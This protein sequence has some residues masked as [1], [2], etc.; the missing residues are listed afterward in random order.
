[1]QLQISMRIHNGIIC[2]KSDKIRKVWVA[3][4]F[5][6]ARTHLA[7]PDLGAHLQFEVVALGNR[8]RTFGKLTFF[9][10]F[11]N[12]FAAILQQVSTFLGCSKAKQ[13][14]LKQERIFLSRKICSKMEK[15]V[16]E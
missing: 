2:S 5:G 3:T 4:F 16:L 7:R 15:D 8:T 10:Q 14:V 11:F 6:V 12:I 13:E 9:Q 1:M